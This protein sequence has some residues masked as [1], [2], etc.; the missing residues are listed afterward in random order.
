MASD[1]NP[2]PAVPTASPSPLLVR[3]PALRRVA[4]VSLGTFPTPVEPLDVLAPELWVKREDLSAEP[5]GGNKV[6]SLEFLLAD[7]SPGDRVTTVGA[8]GSTHVLA[9]AIYARKLGANPRVYRW[10]QEMNAMAQA[11]AERIGREVDDGPVQR[12]VAVAYARALMARWRGARWVPAGG[13]SPLGVLGHVEAGIELAL[14]VERGLMPAPRRVVL[15]LGTGGTAAG[16]ALGAAIGG[17]QTEVI[18]VRVVP[19]VVANRRRV[20]RLVSQTARLIHRLTGEAVDAPAPVRVVHSFYGGAYGRKVP[21]AESAAERCLTET[22]I[23]VDSTYS[24]KALAAAI[25]IAREEGGT[26]LFWLSF[27]GRWLGT[28]DRVALG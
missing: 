7:V 9:T 8:A 21:V 3:Y 6:R 24:A 14:Q 22:G 28:R 26:T 25:S 15:P 16:I 23:A 11:V 1:R 4:R 27:D 13:S 10:M 19:R 2:H 12:T 20:K 5:L 18:G 17:L